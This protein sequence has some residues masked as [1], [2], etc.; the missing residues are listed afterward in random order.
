MVGLLVLAGLAEGVGLLALL[1]ILE[2]AMG[3][4]EPSGFARAVQ[5][6]LERL[7]VEPALGPLLALIFLAMLAKGVLLWL[8]MRQVGYTVAA[9]SAEL[10]R[11]LV[12]ALVRARYGF[13]RDHPAGHIINAG[14]TEARRAA[15]A[16]KDACSAFADAVQGLIY[17]VVVVLVS[18]QVALLAPLV[19]GGLWL[20]LLGLMT[21]A[22]QAGN[23]RTRVMKGFVGRLTALLPN[24]KPVKAMG[25][26]AEVVGLIEEDIGAYKQAEQKA[27]M[28][29]ETLASFRE[30][31]IVLLMVAGL[32]AALQSGALAFSVV[33]ALAILFYRLLMIVGRLQTNYQAVIH[34]ESAFWS[35]YDQILAAEAA[36]EPLHDAAHRREPPP[37][38]ESLAFD[39]VSFAYEPGQPVLRSVSF[40][41]P[42]GQMAALV[43]PSGAGKTTL[44]DLAVGL[45]EPDRGAVRVD[46]VPLAEVDLLAWRRQIGYVPQELL[47][48]HGTVLYNVTLGDPS[49]TR[50]AAERALRAAGA[51]T[52]VEAHPDGLDRVIGERGSKVSGGQ[53]QRLMLARALVHRPRLLILDEA[54]TGLDPKTEAAVCEALRALRGEITILAVSHQPALQRAADLVVEVAGGGVRV[55]PT[56]VSA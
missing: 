45:V 32:Y 36:Q 31:L 43:G 5:G 48:F 4:D 12:R 23:A 11:R 30:P 10:R 2:L 16:Y 8:A 29:V 6:G 24:M 33:L 22:R 56:L 18:W 21:M 25:R 26:E 17:V 38:R 49:L 19:G 54:T 40:E 42:A 14:S 35:L 27:V 15:W 50:E 55:R 51:W 13:F 52:F 41:V 7:G 53:G 9:V 37:L 20:A 39:G 34:G 44:T 47:L 28:A 3:V 46:G 1:P